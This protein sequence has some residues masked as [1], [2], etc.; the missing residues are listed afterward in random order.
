M[1]G[2]GKAQEHSQLAGTA[3][4][5]STAGARQGTTTTADRIAGSAKRGGN[6]G[7]QYSAQNAG[8]HV[9]DPEIAEGDCG[10]LFSRRE[11][12]PK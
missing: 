3:E 12:C 9:A 6:R 10:V 4:G 8:C 7:G 5:A 1:V 2:K 11:G